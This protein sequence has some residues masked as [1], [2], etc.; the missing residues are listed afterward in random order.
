MPSGRTF[1]AAVVG[2]GVIGCSIAWRLAQTGLR[3][4]LLERQAIGAEAS[5]AAG[6]ML[7]PLAEADK[8]DSFLELATAS[9]RLYRTLSEE[10][11]EVTGINIEYR[12]DGTL[13]PALNEA[14]ETALERRWKWQQEAGFRVERL[15]APEARLLEPLLSEAARGALLF[16]DDHQVNNRRLVTALATAARRAGVAISEYT[17]ALS[18][19]TEQSEVSRLVTTQRSFETERVVIAAGSWSSQIHFP[20]SASR[21]P[22]EP[23]RGQMVAFNAAVQMPS[24]VMYSRRGYLIPRLEGILIA[25]STTERVGFDKSVTA[26]GISTIISSAIEITPAVGK[27]QRVD[28]WA[29]LRPATPDGWP[30][31]GADPGIV[32][33]FYATGHYRNGIL[34]TP[35]TARLITELIVS[36]RTTIDLD[37]F[38]VTRFE[39]R[40]AA[41]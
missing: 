13:F 24:R 18:I 34:L 7:A 9:R 10:L 38:S 41:G 22:I 15:S 5:M 11:L 19:D 1:D 6:G 12:T 30:V 40:A 39:H 17:E 21:F 27:M 31:I 33:L 26:D 32:G 36:G 23:V 8:Q 28:A 29:G 2:G 25:G 14:D 4:V 35:I 20:P 37:P 16:P 3:V